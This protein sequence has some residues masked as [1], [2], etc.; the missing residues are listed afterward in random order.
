MLNTKFD[1]TL[2]VRQFLLIAKARLKSWLKTWLK[3]PRKDTARGD[4]RTHAPPDE[5]IACVA[6]TS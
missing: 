5:G 2:I 1:L 4:L 3:A 6:Q